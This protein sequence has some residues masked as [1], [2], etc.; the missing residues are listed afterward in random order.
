MSKFEEYDLY[1][2]NKDFLISDTVLTFTDPGGRLMAL[3]P[4]VTLSIIRAS[5]D[6]LPG[7]QK[8]CYTENVYR[9]SQE[10]DS[11]REILQTGLES[12][13]TISDYDIAEVVTLAAESLRRI[14][15]QRVLVLSHLGILSD[16][17]DGVGLPAEARQR[18]LGMIAGKN[19]HDLAAL[20]AAQGAPAAP[21]AALEELLRTAGAPDEV[22]PRLQTLGCAPAAVAQLR[23]ICGALAAVGLGDALRID[24]SVVNDMAY[25]NGVVFQGFVEGVPVSVV[26]GGQ[27]DRLMARMGRRSGAIGF[28]VYLDA[29]ERLADDET[30]YEEDV[31]L[32]YDE[33][34]DI[35]ALSRAVRELT[36]RGERVSVQR[37]APARRNYRRLA[38][39][40]GSG[41][42]YDDNA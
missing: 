35:P 8:L 20:C 32:L 15:P 23:G 5:R 27:Y 14:A 9:V 3:K 24:F 18:A 40:N 28:A 33:T 36:A 19:L 17:L 34:A 11:F 2:R 30:P 39:W 6:D 31:V 13:G 16:L 22:L 37:H 10:R 29:L 12:I 21:A 25:Y 26:S 7:V 1:A 38:H 42:V 41:V 4:D